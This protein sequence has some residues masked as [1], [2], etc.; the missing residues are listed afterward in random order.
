MAVQ[1]QDS[2]CI[3][4]C[5]SKS[6]TAMGRP[7]A[8]PPCVSRTAPHI[9]HGL[10]G[11][12]PA[13]PPCVSRTAPPNHAPPWAGRRPP[14]HVYH[15]LPPT[16]R[17]AWRGN[18]RLALHMYQGLP[19]QITHRHGQAGGC[20][21]MC[22][23]DCPPHHARSGGATSGLPSI[24]IKDCPSTSHTAMGRPEA[25]PPCVSRTAPHITHGLEGQPPACP[26]ARPT[27]CRM[28]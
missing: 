3:K 23:M 11:Q 10:E 27:K 24:C 13:C 6:R 28:R 12:P 17:T 26:W 5:P 16:S 4:D 25:A 21:S 15:G 9:T 1:R 20:P 18:L 19:L 8:A 14:L 2:M 7:E 22:I